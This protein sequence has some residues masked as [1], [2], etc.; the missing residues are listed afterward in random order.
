MSLKTYNYISKKYEMFALNIIEKAKM[1][2]LNNST[3]NFT[4]G[5]KE[6]QTI[7]VYIYN[8]T[9]TKSNVLITNKVE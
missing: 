4:G 5:L 6:V 3:Q 9:I 2:T 1:A 8:L 7:K